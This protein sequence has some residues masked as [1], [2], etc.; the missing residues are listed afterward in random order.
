M[1]TSEQIDQVRRVARL[2]ALRAAV[3][4]VASE[5]LDDQIPTIR[6]TCS[7]DFEGLVAGYEFLDSKGIAIMGGAL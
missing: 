1:L 3:L 4:S 2:E 5:S 7:V 6:I